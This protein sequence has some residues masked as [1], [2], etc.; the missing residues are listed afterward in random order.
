MI[1]VLYG[2]HVR[3]I[4]L[5]HHKTLNPIRVAG[6]EMDLSHTCSQLEKKSEVCDKGDLIR[7]VNRDGCHMWDR[8][9]SLFPEHLI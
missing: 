4:L 7:G 9:C 5:T 8:K 1:C 3:W 6:D 2:F